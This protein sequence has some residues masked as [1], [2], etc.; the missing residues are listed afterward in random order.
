MSCLNKMVLNKIITTYYPDVR[1]YTLTSMAYEVRENGVCIAYF[2]TQKNLHALTLN[3]MHET[4]FV[5][6]HAKRDPKCKVLIWTATGS[7]A[8]SSGAAF[9][10]NQ[11]V[12][13]AP[14]VA[15]AYRAQKMCPGNPGD[16]ALKTQTLAFWDFPKP[17]IMAINGLAVGGGANIALM[18]YG[19]LVLASSNAR[20]KWPFNKLGLS[21]ELGSSVV[22]AGIVGIPKAKRIMM[23]GEWLSA[24]GAMGMGLVNEVVEPERLLPRAIEMAEQMAGYS[25]SGMFRIKDIMNRHTRAQLE[26]ILDH[27]AAYIEEGIMEMQKLVAAKKAS[28]KAK[29]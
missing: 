29:L 27:E 21:P 2:D 19:D 7:K 13:C 23:L 9:G 17:V 4:F 28:K 22:L 1:P 25:P 11:P 24:E 6:E 3:Q 12:S 10:L 15:D 16:A 5:L 20:F 14:E 26:E 18:N 8:F